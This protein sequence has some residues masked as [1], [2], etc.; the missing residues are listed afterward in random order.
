MNPVLSKE[1]YQRFRGYKGVIILFF[2][3]AFIGA[4]ALA[5]IYLLWITNKNAFILGQNFA[6]FSAL[7][8]FQLIVLCFVIPA[9]TSGAITGEKERKTLDVLLVTKLHEFHIIFG[10]M[11]SSLAFVILLLIATLPLYGLV[12]ILGGIDPMQLLALFGFYFITSILFATIGMACS[13]SINRTGMSTVCAYILT[14]FISLGTFVLA[15]FIDAVADIAMKVEADKIYTY[16]GIVSHL[17]A[18]NPIA[19]LTAILKGEYEDILVLQYEG[20]L[21]LPYWVIYT[22]F[23]IVLSVLLLCYSAWRINPLK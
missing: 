8:T 9:L 2:Y 1:I 18:T 12:L 16:K 7:A 23:C 17:L 22:L 21:V 15:F 4:F 13:V 3:L 6:V 14:A 11:L 20:I 10:K 19:V 5:S